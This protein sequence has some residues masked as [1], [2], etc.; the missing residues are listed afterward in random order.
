MG[1]ALLTADQ[2]SNNLKGLGIGLSVLIGLILFVVFGFSII[3]AINSNPNTIV[4]TN[5]DICNLVPSGSVKGGSLNVTPSFWM[6]NLLF[7]VGYLVSNA[8]YLYNTSP[9]PNAP[10][11]KVKNRRDQAFTAIVVSILVTLAIVYARYQTGCETLVGIF[12]SALVM[13][14]LGSL[15]YY[16]ASVCGAG[17]ADIFGIVSGLLSPNARGSTQV[18]IA[19]PA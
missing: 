17:N 16:I 6:A 15:W 8:M 4:V 3:V 1:V 12:I 7:F 2:T 13:I 11:D 9:Y 14:P 18:C 19:T 10:D 5:Y